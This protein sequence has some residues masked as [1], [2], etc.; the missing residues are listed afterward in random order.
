MLKEPVCFDAV[1]RLTCGTPN[2]SS[3]RFIASLAFSSLFSGKR[4][5]HS[6]KRP[7]AVDSTKLAMAIPSFQS[8]LKFFTLS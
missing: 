6:G 3:A 7:G 8:L 1:F 2:Q 4:S 5:S